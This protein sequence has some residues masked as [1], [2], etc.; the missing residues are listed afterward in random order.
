MKFQIDSSKSVVNNTIS[1]KTFKENIQ[2]LIKNK[3]SFYITWKIW[4]SII[5]PN[6]G[7]GSHLL[8]PTNQYYEKLKK[9]K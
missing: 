7:I 3:G 9:N 5:I 1:Q 2:L 6:E 4:G 8:Q